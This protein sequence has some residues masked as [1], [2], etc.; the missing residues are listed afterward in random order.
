MHKLWNTGF[1]LR[2]EPS[3]YGPGYV[4][5]PTCQHTKPIDAQGLFDLYETFHD[6]AG[7]LLLEARPRLMIEPTE[8]PTALERFAKESALYTDDE[9]AGLAF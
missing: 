8:W 2:L 4:I 7:A 9:K 6:E 1:N 5:I 3:Q